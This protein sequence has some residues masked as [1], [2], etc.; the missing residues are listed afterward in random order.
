MLIH[1][2]RFTDMQRRRRPGRGRPRGHAATGSSSARAAIRSC[3]RLPSSS[4]TAIM[5]R[6]PRPSWSREDMAAL[7]GP[8]PAFDEV[9]AEM[10]RVAGE[11]GCTPSTAPRPTPWSTSTIPTGISVIAI[12]GDKLSRGLTLEGLCVSLLPP[13]QP[14]VRH[15]HADGPLV[16]LPPRLSGPLPAV[17]HRLAGRLVREDHRRRARSCRPSSRRWRRSGRRRRS[18]VSGSASYPDGLLVTSPQKLKHAAT[19]LHL[20]Q[21]RDSERDRLLP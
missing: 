1:V 7:A 12:G 21:R 10:S 4:S 20:V 5:C 16:R 17:H 6:P 18:S 2:T 13:R 8:V 3:E 14:H 9:W 11:R 19:L 15:P